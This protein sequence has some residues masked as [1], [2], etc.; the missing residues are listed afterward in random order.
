MRTRSQLRKEDQAV[1]ATEKPEKKK[2]KK[3]LL[4]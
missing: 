2:T 4:E 3:E 1:A